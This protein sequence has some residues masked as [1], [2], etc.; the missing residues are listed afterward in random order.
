[1]NNQ[2]KEGCDVSFVRIDARADVFVEEIGAEGPKL[3]HGLDACCGSVV[4]LGVKGI[5]AI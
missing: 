1:M 3:E 2:S 5:F 4:G